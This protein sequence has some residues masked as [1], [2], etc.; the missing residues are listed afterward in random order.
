MVDLPGDTSLLKF[1]ISS[2]H[3]LSPW[4]VEAVHKRFGKILC[5]L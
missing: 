3:A 1:I 5:N 4:L 2:G